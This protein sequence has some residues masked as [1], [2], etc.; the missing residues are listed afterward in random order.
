[1]EK[2]FNFTP[3][4]IEK[5]I[6]DA[7][8][9]KFSTE[10]VVYDSGFK[11]R[12]EFSAALNV[13]IS[14]KGKATWSVIFRVDGKRQ[15]EALGSFGRKDA[16]HIDVTMGRA[17][18]TK[19]IGALASTDNPCAPAGDFPKMEELLDTFR[20]WKMKRGS[21]TRATDEAVA[22]LARHIM[23]TLGKKRCNKVTT[24]DVARIT[25][26]KL[27]AGQPYLHD[28]I[29]AQTSALF[30]AANEM[31]GL[32]ISNPV[33]GQLKKV[34][35]KAI[36]VPISNDD[37]GELW[38]AIQELDGDVR[39]ILELRLLMARRKVEV[40]SLRWDQLGDL[41]Q[42][43]WT[44]GEGDHKAGRIGDASTTVHIAF[45]RRVFD[46]LVRRQAA[47]KEGD[48]FVFP[49]T[50]RSK[51]VSGK[52]ANVAWTSAKLH[53]PIR[54][55]LSVD[56]HMH[57]FRNFFSTR[58]LV[59]L[60]IAQHVISECMTHSKKRDAVANGGSAT[61]VGYQGGFDIT[62]QRA[63]FEAWHRHLDLAAAGQLEDKVDR[64]FDDTP[65]EDDNVLAFD[66]E[67]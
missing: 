19:F 60:H 30:T 5:L 47:A 35:P 43:I 25:T 26:P 17:A 58:A 10:V 13:R 55:R 29:I 44:M 28:Q 4:R 31:L 42:G 45:P 54:S 36:V 37:L 52:P 62:G 34:Q 8:A 53:A 2:T 24:A 23:P 50:D 27:N 40:E 41:R 65:F 66:K 15:R 20:A 56:Y 51:H 46:I 7:R 12:G 64:P 9:G 1:M 48:V 38:R 33:M 57:N 39:D 14:P 59:D 21:K 49:Q 16:G 67:A 3:K 61:T 6:A 32:Q 11:M 22:V 63:A 18:A